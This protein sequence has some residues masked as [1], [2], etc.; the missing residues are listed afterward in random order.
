MKM[1]NIKNKSRISE[2]H[3]CFSEKAHRQFAR[4]HLP[5]A[6][7]CNIQCNYCIRK[8]DCVNETRPGVT[9]AVLRPHEAIERVRAVMERNRGV[10]VVGI[11][12]PG[13][14]LAND[15]TFETFRLVHE[16]FPEAILCIS[17]NGLMLPERLGDLRACGVESITITINA[18]TSETAEKIYSS[19]FQKGRRL[20][21]RAAACALLYN[22]WS[23]LSKALAAGLVVKVN[24]ILTP[25]INDDEVPMIALNAASAGA[26][27]MNVMPLIPQ[28]AFKHLSRP[29]CAML[30]AARKKCGAYMPQMTHCKQ[31]RADAFGRLGEDG[32]AELE[33]LHSRL[34]EDYCE[35]V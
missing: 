21:G 33:L 28:A 5:V 22:Q 2:Q 16:E 31:C 18:L 4:L 14:P 12:G 19:V 27:I 6:P 10:S 7:E 8:F 25:G 32:D 30:D 13:D 35:N 34:G 29:S 26:E 20:T 24:T 1:E 3:P 9:S 17:T 11:A 15:A 23:G